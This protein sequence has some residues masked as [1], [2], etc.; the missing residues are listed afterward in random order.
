MSDWEKT[1]MSDRLLT[2]EEIEEVAGWRATHIWD[3]DGIIKAQDTKTLKEV[4]E[5]GVRVR[6]ASQRG[7][8][9]VEF[10]DGD[11]IDQTGALIEFLMHLSIL[12]PGCELPDDLTII[13]T[14]A[15]Q[16]LI[17]EEGK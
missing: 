10:N 15:L 6:L 16:G 13:P 11:F 8:P 7:T 5:A 1:V 14:K 4:G 17:P 9:V 2:E 3:I 12:M